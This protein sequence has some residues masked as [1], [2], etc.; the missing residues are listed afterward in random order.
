[1]LDTRPASPVGGGRVWSD[2][3]LGGMPS[4]GIGESFLPV[5][6]FQSLV[7]LHYCLLRKRLDIEKGSHLVVL[8]WPGKPF[9]SCSGLEGLTCQ[10][11]RELVTGA[12]VVLLGSALT[13]PDTPCSSLHS[14]QAPDQRALE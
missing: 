2:S 12:T 13:S 1:M 4:C 7:E 10:A 5:S 8:M 11:V 6:K 3:G 14:H 9:G